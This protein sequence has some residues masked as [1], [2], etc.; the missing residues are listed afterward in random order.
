MQQTTAP[1]CNY[2]Y[3]PQALFSAKSDAE[4][5]EATRR[6][7]Q[8]LV[9]VVTTTAAATAANAAAE[10]ENLLTTLKRD[11]ARRV[12]FTLGQLQ[13]RLLEKQINV[14]D[15]Q[16]RNLDRDFDKTNFEIMRHLQK[17]PRGPFFAP[18]PA[19]F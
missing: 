18:A 16:A 12:N 8:A 2:H 6:M 11:A 10:S 1:E 5:L 7:S 14:A 9:P 3:A 17:L 4:T 13:M 15:K 19:F